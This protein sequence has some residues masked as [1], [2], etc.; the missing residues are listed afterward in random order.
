M[1]S[2]SYTY[3]S[4]MRCQVNVVEQVASKFVQK[5][6]LLCVGNTVRVQGIHTYR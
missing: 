3:A 2:F 4:I 1:L 6:P 5:N